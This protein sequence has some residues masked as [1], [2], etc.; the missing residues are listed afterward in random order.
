MPA[1]NDQSPPAVVDR[2][3]LLVQLRAD[4]AHRL[5]DLDALEALATITAGDAGEARIAE[6]L[7]VLAREILW[8]RAAELERRV[9]RLDENIDRLL[10]MAGTRFSP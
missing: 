6:H 8:L 5:Q 4:G 2:D 7:G 9:D 3:A 1:D 10:M